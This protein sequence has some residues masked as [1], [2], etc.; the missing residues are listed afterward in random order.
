MPVTM[1]INK[2]KV[3]YSFFWTQLNRHEK[4]PWFLWQT[5]DKHEGSK[6]SLHCW[7]SYNDKRVNIDN[8]TVIDSLTFLLPA[9]KRNPKK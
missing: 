2:I 4:R 6:H 8:Y 1:H 7:I 9:K 5:V 3:V